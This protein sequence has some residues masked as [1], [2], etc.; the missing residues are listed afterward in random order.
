MTRSLLGAAIALA[1]SL[2]AAG[3]ANATPPQDQACATA[4]SYSQ[5]HRGV[6]LLVLRDGKVVC[7]AYAAGDAQTGHEL[8][9]GTKSFVGLM[10]AA[11]VQDGLLTLDEPVSD[12][13]TEWRGDPL[14]GAVTIRQLL[15]MTA[16]LPSVVGRPPSYADAVTAPFNA[17]PGAR[18]QYGPA[19]MQVFG[20]VMKRKLA[21]RGEP[22]D[23]L[24]YLKRRVLD[25]IGLRY[26]DWRSGPDGLPLLPQGAVMTAAEWAKAGE[27]I[28]ADG[29]QDGKLLVDADAFAALFQGSAA[30]PA[31]GLTWWLPRPS[32]A[33]DVVTA[34]SDIPRRAADLPTDLVMAAGAGDQ[35]L[36]VIPSLKLIIVRQARLDIRALTA[37]RGPD[38]WSDVDFLKLLIAP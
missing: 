27:F 20:A 37:P 5:A 25:P 32:P 11:A 34:S 28:R 23:P 10:A 9:S 30:N 31:Y 21:A 1:L 6:S 14:K 4:A 17:E 33:S 35:R 19:P 18:F 26:T 2:G 13:L 22:D 24:I 38:S 36:Y 16:G 8:Y 3:A 12:T 15:S 29:R 7:E